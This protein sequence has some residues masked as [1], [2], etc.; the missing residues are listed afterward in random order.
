[1]RDSVYT[2]G[3]GHSPRI[4]AGRDD[5]LRD[6]QLMLNDA[7]SRGRVRAQDIVLVGPRG[8]GKT[9]ALFA[10]GARAATQGFEVVNLQA[11]AGHAGLVES[12]LQRAQT[13]IAADAGP[14]RRT[15]A[16]FERLSS[17]NVSVAGFGAGLSTRDPTGSSSSPGRVDAGSLAHALAQL[18][19]EVRHDSPHGGLLVTVD[20]MQVASAAD[21]AL[22]AATLHRL[23]VDHPGAVVLFAGTGLPFTA[24]AL[25]KA[26]VTHPDRLFVLHDIPLTL[27]VGDARYAV[28][29]P[30]RVAG[31]TWEPEA[32]DR[33]VDLSNGYPAHLQLFADAAWSA[34]PG[35]H[36]ITLHDVQTSL[37]TVGAQLEQRTLG[38]RWD[39]ITDRQMEFMAALALHGGRAPISTIAA[40]L[41]RE[42][43]E[44]SWLRE[45]LI[46]EGDI[47]AP[48]RGLIA[49]AVPLFAA[50][51]LTR[52]EE[53]STDATVNVLTLDQM[54]TNAGL[55]PAGNPERAGG[56]SQLGRSQQQT[57][58]SNPPAGGPA[59][60]LTP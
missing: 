55:P 37:P 56:A 11:A 31:V 26:G 19:G 42:Q 18:A 4:L 35:P 39:R 3:A 50:Y 54:R 58:R 12:L 13:S 14:W 17:I 36:T 57:R 38:P 10:F 24:E 16:A 6:W 51:V 40:T 15:R 5:L 43:G 23:N 22:V 45:E 7:D 60:G 59:T 52:Y 41:G 2:P 28:I 8:V 44:M 49:M 9:A 29:E 34:A 30:A 21:L 53:A 48:R 20:E 25:R 46:H 47:Y 32:A 33:L 1:M 27:D